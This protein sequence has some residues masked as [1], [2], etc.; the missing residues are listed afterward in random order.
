[1]VDLDDTLYPQRSYLTGAVVAV[2]SRAA[3]WGLD[4]DLFA[5]TFQRVLDEGSD[6]GRTINE[7]LQRIG[8]P[9]P[10]DD[11]LVAALVQA[12]WGFC[13]AH[14]T[15]Y[16]GVVE[17]LERLMQRVPVACLTDGDG[18]VQRAKLAALGVNRYF[19]QVVITDEVGGRTRRKPDPLGIER[20]ASF[21]DLPPDELVVIGDRPDKD[22]ALALA[23][24]AG[25]VR[26]RQ[27]EYRHDA[28]PLGVSTVDDFESA[29]NLVLDEFLL[30]I[31]HE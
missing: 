1:M 28:S 30:P 20:I 14:L 15:P 27:G 5:R 29:T 13:P 6:S 10:N 3:A 26:V 22:V 31:S 12:F 23:V 18:P 8:H 21:W 19:D 11:E 2:A 24:G 9:T 25:I 4:N 7:T 17:S 16:P